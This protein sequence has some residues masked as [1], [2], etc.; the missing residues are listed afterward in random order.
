MEL[1]ILRRLPIPEVIVFLRNISVILKAG[2]PLPKA[3]TLIEEDA[4]RHL[5][6]LWQYLRRTTESGRS[7]AD[8]LETA[9]RTFPTIAINLVR[10]GELS[11]TLQTNL[12]EIVKHLRKAQ[13]LKRKIQSASLYPTFVLV[14]VLGLIMAIGTLVLPRL[15]PV[16]ESLGVTLPWTT[17]LLLAIARFFD[18]HGLVFTGGLLGGTFLSFLVTRLA[19]V[20]PLAH[21]ILLHIPFVGKVL[22]RAAIAQITSTLATLLR[23]G[24]PLPQ[25]IKA[26]AETTNNRVYRRILY[27]ALPLVESGHLFSEGLRRGGKYFPPM[28]TMLIE[29]GEQTGS[30][31][32]TLDELAMYYE[33]EVDYAVRDMMT[34]LE[35]I[36]LI[37]IGVIV[38]FTVIAIITPIYEVTST[39]G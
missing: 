15:I 26:V 3:L 38:G 34:A 28:A 22:R 7:F 4:P 35:P 18:A 6:S 33:S 16:F 24:I 10:T 29:I 23:S 13:D 19:R 17:R 11:G 2:I 20:K 31:E 27:E 1:T 36:L 37:I 25:A 32:E 5:K 14:A 12:E 21:T 30:L 9:P 39:V 8:A